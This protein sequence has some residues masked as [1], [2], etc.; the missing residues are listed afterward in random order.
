MYEYKEL[1]LTKDQYNRIVLEKGSMMGVM[2]SSNVSKIDIKWLVEASE[3]H[4]KVFGG[5][6][7]NIYGNGMPTIAMF[8]NLLRKLEEYEQNQKV[9]SATT[10]RHDKPIKGGGEDRKKDKLRRSF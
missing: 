1:E 10:D 6:K 2:L 9:R 4:Q 7:P 5:P 8:K 3:I